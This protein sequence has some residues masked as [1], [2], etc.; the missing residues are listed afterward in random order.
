MLAFISPHIQIFLTKILL[1]WRSSYDFVMAKWI[2]K[3][4]EYLKSL[5]V[6]ISIIAILIS[7]LMIYSDIAYSNLAKKT[8]SVEINA[9]LLFFV[10]G[11]LVV[12]IA[13]LISITVL[14][15]VKE[16]EENLQW[17]RLG[18]SH[19]QTVTIRS[20]QAITYAVIMLISTV[21]FNIIFFI[22]MH[23]ALLLGIKQMNYELLFIINYYFYSYVFVC[24]YYQKLV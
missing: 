22:L 6:S 11:P 10:V 5:T 15:S 18:I 24:F 23:K 4:K 19:K 17:E 16:K 20:V 9:V 21:F 1:A 14:S 13:N 3:D 7:E 2:L 12:V 8:A